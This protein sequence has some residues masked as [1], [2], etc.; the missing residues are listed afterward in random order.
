[1]GAGTMKGRDEEKRRRQDQTLN[2]AF[3]CSKK[4]RTAGMGKG[5]DEGTSVFTSALRQ[6]STGEVKKGARGKVKAEDEEK[7]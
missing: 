5:D 6:R 3:F 4:E 2:S 1:M 7:E